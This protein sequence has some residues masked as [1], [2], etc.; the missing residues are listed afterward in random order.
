MRKEKELVS[1]CIPAYNGGGLIRRAID[2]SLNQTYKNIEVIIVDDNSTDDTL[3]IISEYANKYK[4]VRIFRNNKNLGVSRNFL[5]TYKL[6]RGKFVQHLGQD[7]WLDSNFVEEKIKAFESCQNI[8]FVANPIK[9]FILDKKGRPK[10]VGRV[11]KKGGI[12]RSDYVF[13]NFYRSNGLIGLFAMPRRGD[14]L[15]AFQVTVKNDFNYDKFYL[16]GMVIDNYFLLSIL[17]KRNSFY[18]TINTNYNTLSH[19]KQ[20]SKQYGLDILSPV[21]LVKYSHIERVGFERFFI[22]NNLKN[23]LFRYRIYKGSELII[24]ALKRNILNRFRSFKL[25][26]EEIN[27]YFKDYSYKEK[28]LTLVGV[29]V[30]VVRK[31]NKVIIN[32]LNKKK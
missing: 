3:D 15:E 28:L 21:E 25:F 5:K 14:I 9:T 16:G 4:N 17:K 6:A 19:P 32:K 13:K 30:L 12:Y 10:L 27:F 24:S 18:Y 26:L 11:S 2:S 8:A 1:I 20:A 29:L 23:Y 7:D 31:I 22:E